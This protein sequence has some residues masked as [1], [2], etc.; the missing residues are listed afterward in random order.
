MVHTVIR[1]NQL[2]VF[3]NEGQPSVYR[4]VTERS[5]TIGDAKSP[6]DEWQRHLLRVAVIFLGMLCYF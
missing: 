3:R 6:F 5:E 2:L 4:L 1:V